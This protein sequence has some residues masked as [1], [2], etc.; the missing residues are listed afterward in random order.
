MA[1]VAAIALTASFPAQADEAPAAAPPADAGDAG[2]S[3][4]GSSN[5]QFDTIEVLGQRKGPTV[6][7]DLGKAI[8]NDIAATFKLTQEDIQKQVTSSTIDIFRSIPGVY[9]E[10]YGNGGIAQ[11]IGLRGWAGNADGIYVAS[12]ID[13]YQRNTYSSGNSNGY[14]DLNVLIPETV[15]S[16]DLIKG[17]FDPRYGGM[18]A[19]GGSLV[20]KTADFV[21]TGFAQQ[22]GSF[23]ESRSV[24]SY[25]Y[26]GADV[27]LYSVL[28]GYKD[29][30]YRQNSAQDQINSFNKATFLLS[31]N[32][33]LSVAAQLYNANY[34]QPGYIPIKTAL[35]GSYLSAEG[36]NDR[37]D[38]T[39]A[40]L[41]VNYTHVEDNFELDSNLFFDR[42]YL[43]R[44]ITRGYYPEPVPPDEQN[45]FLDDR[46]TVGGGVDPYWTFDLPG[47]MKLDLR[48]GALVHVDFA[49]VDKYPGID[50]LPIPAPQPYFGKLSFYNLA[51]FTEINPA[52]YIESSIK[53][54]SWFKLTA[55]V[56]YDDFIYDDAVTDFVAP[57]NKRFQQ[58]R[59]YTGRLTGRGGI[60]ILPADNWTLYAN[61]GQAVY[62]PSAVNQLNLT[63]N[64]KTSAIRSNEGGIIYDNPELGL[65]VGGDIYYTISTAEIGTSPTTGE[66][67]NLGRSVRVGE[68]FDAKYRVYQDRGTEVQLTA[69]YSQVRA[70]LSH[71][72]AGYV[73]TVPDW[74]AAYGID[75]TTPVKVLGDPD[76][77]VVVNLAH[78]FFGEYKLTTDGT[79]SSS[80]YDRIQAKVTYE[81]PTLHDLSVYLAAI[82][83]PHNTLSEI[84]YYTNGVRYVGI[85]PSLRLQGGFA[86]HFGGK[87]EPPPAT[88]AYVPPPIV[89]PAASPSSYLVFFDFNKSD[90]TSQAVGI[91]DTAAKNAGP[92]K[93]TQLTVTGH[94][95]TV[96]SDAYNLRLSR[97]RAESVAAQLEK[98]GVASSEIAIVA[99][100]KRDLL[101]PT[102]DGVKEPQ[103]RRVQIVYSGGASS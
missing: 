57:D 29:D 13:G 28:V 79:Q 6:R 50:G 53:P 51:N 4:S 74:Q 46:Y 90:L 34:G 59:D 100:G 30:G 33:K 87:D 32:D 7:A 5:A 99:K 26:D 1:S 97:R 23:G 47:D 41:T 16:I 73:T 62:A 2:Q 64:L 17:P 55:G 25:G 66:Q 67:I 72:D 9:V 3:A 39:Q 42:I 86:V 84:T 54:V 60:A 93:V 85:E 10:D 81:N 75:V 103:N 43:Y 56:R 37:G 63:P 61:I 92:A 94:T 8:E 78:Q 76:E 70:R 88:V 49:R 77:R 48:A 19:Y 21:P 52:S 71:N 68:D 69:S 83:F 36:P 31:D 12:Y 14:N 45:I 38:K 18:L 22:F 35:T 82:A 65:H 20:I 95:D 15:G 98:D 58:I 24:L 11:G 80:P 40:T 101:V 102:A 44:A 91:V 89:A 96:G 27:K